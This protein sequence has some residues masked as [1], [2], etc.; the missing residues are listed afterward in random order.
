MQK[1]LI[2]I[3]LAFISGCEQK[4]K[5]SIPS[6]LAGTWKSDDAD[7]C[8]WEF[9]IEPNGVI[10]KLQNFQ[11]L[12]VDT[13]VGDANS[14]IPELNIDQACTLG[15]IKVNYEPDN[16]TLSV[17]VDTDYYMMYISNQIIEGKGSDIFAGSVS[18]DGLMWSVEWKSF[19]GMIDGPPL[20][21]N[22]PIIQ[23]VTFHKVK[24]N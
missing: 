8:L 17:Q 19:S 20:D 3:A 7:R 23:Q 24:G 5:S 12:R 22:N 6:S 2:M 10:S 21:V 9:T 1:I 18:E 15:Q 11:G 13:A 4:N 16:R 14:R